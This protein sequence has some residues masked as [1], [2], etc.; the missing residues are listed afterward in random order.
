MREYTRARVHARAF[1]QCSAVQCSAVQCSA[2]Q[3]SAVQCSAVQCSAVASEHV[4]ECVRALRA[5]V[6]ARHRHHLQREV[7]RGCRD[8]PPVQHPKPKTTAARNV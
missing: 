3:C 5:C 6:S 2:V 7:S 8:R 1:V 4:R